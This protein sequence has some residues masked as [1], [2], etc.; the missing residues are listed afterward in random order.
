MFRGIIKGKALTGLSSNI[1]DK[2]IHKIAF[3]TDKP[4]SRSN[5][6]NKYSLLRH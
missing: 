4:K 2:Q 5:Q 3:V 1:Y 6:K